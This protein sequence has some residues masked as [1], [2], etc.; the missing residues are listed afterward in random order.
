MTQIK[1]AAAQT[2]RADAN[3]RQVRFANRQ[4]YIRGG[5]KQTRFA[6]LS[7]QLAH[8]GFH[9]GTTPGIQRLNFRHA[10][11]DANDPV[12]NVSE[13]RRGHRPHIPQPKHT[14]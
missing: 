9:D 6:R 2:G 7:D 5:T 14:D 1:L 11:V 13:A 12:A 8:S 3:K 10:D 4:S